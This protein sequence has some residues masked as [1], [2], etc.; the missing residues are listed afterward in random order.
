M[1]VGMNEYF[2]ERYSAGVVWKSARLEKQ[3]NVVRVGF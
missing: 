2:Y 3:R 1:G